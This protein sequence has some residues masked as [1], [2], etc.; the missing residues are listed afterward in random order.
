MH[1]GAA[2]RFFLAREHQ[3]VR[4]TVSQDYGPHMLRPGLASIFF[5]WGWLCYAGCVGGNVPAPA[6][7]RPPACRG[8]AF[9]RSSSSRV[10]SQIEPTRW[11]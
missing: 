7:G 3:M 6:F 2:E 10:K 9:Q 4:L 5:D 11:P 1:V 8:V